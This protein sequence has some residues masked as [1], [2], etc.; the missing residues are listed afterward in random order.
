VLVTRVNGPRIEVIKQE[1]EGS[2]TEE[3]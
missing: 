3:N 2:N 1:P